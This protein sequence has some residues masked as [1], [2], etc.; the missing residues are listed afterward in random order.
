MAPGT[1]G[2]GTEGWRSSSTQTS[3]ENGS[4]LDEE[5]GDDAGWQAWTACGV[6]RESRS[7]TTLPCDLP[8]FSGSSCS[9]QRAPASHVVHALL[10]VNEV[11]Q[12]EQNQV[13]K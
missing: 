3:C 5:S 6:Q 4:N 7:G 11:A 1:D 12:R 9:L 13:L 10:H 8:P 2:T